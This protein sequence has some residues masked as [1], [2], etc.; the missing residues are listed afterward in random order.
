M[1]KMRHAVFTTCC[2][3]CTDGTQTSM[4]TVYFNKARLT[5]CEVAILVL[6]W[7]L[8]LI[9][10]GILN[11]G[12]GCLKVWTGGLDFTF[13]LLIFLSPRWHFLLCLCDKCNGYNTDSSFS[14]REKNCVGLSIHRFAS[15]CKL[16]T[17]HQIIKWRNNMVKKRKKNIY[18]KQEISNLTNL[19]LIKSVKRNFTFIL[20]SKLWLEFVTLEDL[21]KSVSQVF[22]LL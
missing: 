2:L 21:L 16:L 14:D 9:I 8:A 6:V 5:L 3:C 17:K 1:L 22:K 7:S 12:A 20:F 11:R 4:P 10:G 19:N 15:L 13:Y 18:N